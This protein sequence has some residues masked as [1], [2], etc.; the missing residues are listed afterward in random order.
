MSEWKEYTISDITE[1]ISMG[2]FGSNIKVDNFIDFGIPV[3]N[4]SNLQGHKLNEESFN[5]VSEE[6]ADSLGKANAY[7]GDVVI[8]HRGTLGQIVYI[9][10]DSKFER[11][12]IS[13]SQFRL[14]LDTSIVRPDFFVYYFHT[15]EGQHKILMNASQVGVPALAR[16]TSTF[17]KV[18][19]S[20]PS[21]KTQDEIMDVV[22][23]LDDKIENNKKIN[24]NLEQQAQALFKSWFIDFEPFKDIKFIDSELGPIPEGW[25]V[26]TL[27]EIATITMGQSPSGESLNDNK[28]GIIFY[29]GRTEFGFR[30][31]SIRLYTTEPSRYAE[32]NSVLLSVRA[33]VGDINRALIK[34]CIGRGL[35]SIRSLFGN[36]SFLYYLM[37]SQRTSLDIYNGEGTVFGSI[38]RNALEG[39]KIIIPPHKIIDKFDEIVVGID[40]AI[41]SHFLENERLSILRDTL[42][43]KLMSGEI[44]V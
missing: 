31:P 44:E 30:Y 34:C 1:E 15:R 2:P 40:S 38:N 35:A 41:K 33:P 22:L 4:G 39:L 21:L 7:R 3:L 27:D 6:K 13:Q 9:P 37:L 25:R 10:N 11:Y 19:I 26:G 17:K 24:E 36:D 29:Q 20:L 16:P 8:T 42:L 32:P 14:K 18:S 5:Y 23:A 28:D 12:V 43:P